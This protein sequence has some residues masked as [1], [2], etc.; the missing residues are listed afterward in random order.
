MLFDDC[1]FEAELGSADRCYVAT[2]AATDY[3]DI[4]STVHMDMF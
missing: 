3:D 1:D 2:W 4:K